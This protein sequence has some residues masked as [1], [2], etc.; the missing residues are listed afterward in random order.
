DDVDKFSCRPDFVVAA[1]SG[2]LVEKDTE[3]LTPDLGIPAQTPPTFLVHAGDDHVS[4]V[5]NSV[6]MYQALM[7]AKIPAELHVYVTGDHGFG[8]RQSE[9]P[10]SKWKERCLDW[11]RNQGLFDKPAVAQ[12]DPD[13]M[14]ALRPI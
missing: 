1:Y 4:D 5:T 6:V 2:Y 8:V 11:M 14:R 9:R 10:C 7:R 3:R 12:P 13:V